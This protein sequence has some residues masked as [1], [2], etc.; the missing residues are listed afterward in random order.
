MVSKKVM[1]GSAFGA[2]IL[3]AGARLKMDS[4][5]GTIWPWIVVGVCAVI[6]G[7]YVFLIWREE[8]A[9]KAAL[10]LVNSKGQENK[11]D[12]KAL[13]LDGGKPIYVD[14]LPSVVTCVKD[15]LESD[16]GGRGDSGA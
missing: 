16:D 7:I 2:V 3:I 9:D 8:R 5:E 1:S 13:G 14:D 10:T 6:F 4:L 11:W 15:S 12:R